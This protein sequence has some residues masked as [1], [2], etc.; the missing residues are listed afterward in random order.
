MREQYWI[1]FYLDS[2]FNVFSLN[3]VVTHQVPIYYIPITGYLSVTELN[4]RQIL[5]ASKQ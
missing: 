4:L 5:C 3:L 1:A 2:I